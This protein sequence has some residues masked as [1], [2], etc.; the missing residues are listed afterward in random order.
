MFPEK[1]ER[2]TIVEFTFSKRNP[3]V[4]YPDITWFKQKLIILEHRQE[5]GLDRVNVMELKG[6]EI[7]I[8]WLALFDHIHSKN[9]YRVLGKMEIEEALTHDL[10]VLRKTAK[11]AFL[12][13]V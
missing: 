10:E 4:N 11:K 9:E 3:G 2:F 12:E 5:S 1:F 8:T 6:D 13:E 7:V